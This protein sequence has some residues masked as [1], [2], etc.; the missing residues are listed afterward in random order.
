MKISYQELIFLLLCISTYVTADGTDNSTMSSYDAITAATLSQMTEEYNDNPDNKEATI[1]ISKAALSLQKSMLEDSEDQDGSDRETGS[2]DESLVE[3]VYDQKLDKL[4]YI[5][6]SQEQDET[7]VESMQNN[8]IEND[9]NT[10]NQDENESNTVIVEDTKDDIMNSKFD[11]NSNDE[12][13]ISDSQDEDELN[14]IRLKEREDKETVDSFLGMRA[15]P[16]NATF[17]ELFKAQINADFA[18]FLIIIPKPVKKIISKN[19]MILGKKIQIAIQGPL[20]PFVVVASKLL[21]LLGNGVIY[22]GDD[23]VKFSAFLSSFDDSELRQ[24]SR[25]ESQQIAGQIM[26]ND[27]SL[28]NNEDETE[29]VV[30]IDGGDR[31]L[32]N[33]NIEGRSITSDSDSDSA[34][35]L[36]AEDGQYE[37]GGN[38]VIEL[39]ATIRNLLHE[40][41]LN[42]DE[43]V[44][45][46]AV[47]LVQIHLNNDKF[48]LDKALDDLFREGEQTSDSGDEIE[49]KVDSKDEIEVE[50]DRIEVEK[51]EIVVEEDEI[52]VEEIEEIEL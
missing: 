44:V 45:D 52:Q 36:V 31:E 27:D 19:F 43:K 24:K 41:N 20:T 2:D 18:P 11:H 51:D 47:D 1:S 39:K 46:R 14:T 15:M 37:I 13:E 8:L 21:K 10:D 4:D 22:I 42:V 35:I 12:I 23:I 48:D 29:I 9:D 50:K 32:A 6:N 38:Q 30:S 34:P 25:L 3:E 16:D 5:L 7:E 40:R 49:D 28:Q 26:S 17:W 33:R